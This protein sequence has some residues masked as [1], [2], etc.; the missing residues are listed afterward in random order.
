MDLS[1]ELHELKK[2][3]Y[4][5]GVDEAG[6]G[7]LAG[8]LVTAAFCFTLPS[9]ELTSQNPWNLVAD[10]KVIQEGQRES[11]YEQIF[12]VTKSDQQGKKLNRTATDE[13]STSQ[14]GSRNVAL[15]EN[16]AADLPSF[17]YTSHVTEV[18]DIDRL[19]ILEATMRSMTFAVYELIIRIINTVGECR[20]KVLVDGNREP[21]FLSSYK[22]ALFNNDAPAILREKVLDWAFIKRNIRLI[23]VRTVVKGDA[24]VM[25]IAAASIVAKVTRDRIMRDLASKFPRYKFEINKGYGTV[26]HRLA[27]GELGPTPA[28]RLSFA[29][30]LGMLKSGT[31][32]V[33]V[34][35][36]TDFKLAIIRMQAKMLPR[37]LKNA[38]DTTN[39][40]SS[41]QCRLCQSSKSCKICRPIKMKRQAKRCID[42][43]I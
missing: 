26:D 1:V 6:R 5:I 27:I 42:S 3:D 39:T 18:G 22:I 38:S 24:T 16:H 21:P 11:I 40:S 19:N 13:S 25:S 10:S 41:G 43:I 8:P 20:V 37:T 30:L 35:R 23:D 28:H 14:N 12:E 9:S 33:P 32:P 17:L 2:Y 34:G 36:E 29:P 15:H 7:P 31:F 4:V